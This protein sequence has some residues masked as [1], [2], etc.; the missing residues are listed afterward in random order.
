V[1]DFTPCNTDL[2]LPTM[3]QYQQI[4]ATPCS[5]YTSLHIFLHK[6]ARNLRWSNSRFWGIKI[7]TRLQECTN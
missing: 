2:Q 6:F 5:L 4:N 1:A 7:L 3:H